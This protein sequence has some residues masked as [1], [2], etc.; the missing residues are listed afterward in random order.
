MIFH[1]FG[2]AEV[3]TAVGGVGNDRGVVQEEAL[4]R[5]VYGA[6]LLALFSTMKSV[7]FAERMSLSLTQRQYRA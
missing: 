1:F 3:P 7:Y 4:G 2:Q 6:T 5:K